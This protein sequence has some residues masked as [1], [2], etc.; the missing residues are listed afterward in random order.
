MTRQASRI[1]LCAAVLAA[2]AV[3][4]H[5]CAT[6]ADFAGTMSNLQRLKFRVASVSGFTVSGIGIAQKQRLADF[7]LMDGV[8]LLA[9]YQGKKLPAN[10]TLNVEAVNP[11]DGT[12][13]SPQTASTLTS[14]AWRLLI[15]GKST[16]AGDI[17]Q[18]IEIPGTGQA[19][20]IPLKIEIDLVR[21]F[22][23]Q[24][25]NDVLNLALALG[26]L[27]SD[28]TRLSLDAQPRVTTPLGEIT[29]PGRITVISKEYR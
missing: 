18:P 2:G 4:N 7:T 8:T 5:G 13:G 15:D 24:C 28:I 19:A 29:Y 10:F 1:L 23:D 6:L 27:K 22:Q 20:I 14:F 11:N 17:T 3:T 9:A 26:G 16:V 21:F 25:Y 12:G